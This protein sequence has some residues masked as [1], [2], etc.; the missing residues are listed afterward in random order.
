[1][2]RVFWSRV[3]D[4]PTEL[5]VVALKEYFR[6]SA[7]WINALA[8]EKDWPVLK[9]QSIPGLS[10]NQRYVEHWTKVLDASSLPSYFK[11]HILQFIYWRAILNPKVLPQ[12]L[13]DPF[14]PFQFYC[15]IGGWFNKD[16]SGSLNFP[17]GSM[18]MYP[19]SYYLDKEP[20]V[21]G[22]EPSTILSK[23]AL[24]GVLAEKP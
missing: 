15:S 13:P 5:H 6:R 19:I 22:L 4:E 20:F 7:L 3:A 16:H 21:Q 18:P 10:F 24:P 11:S 2:E 9:V 17:L 12:E 1:M 8:L 23:S 14:S